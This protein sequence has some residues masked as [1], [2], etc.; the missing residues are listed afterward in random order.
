MRVKEARFE[1][2]HQVL[3]E[4]NQDKMDACIIVPDSQVEKRPNSCYYR[5]TS[6]CDP[7]S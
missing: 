2:I 1:L 3:N 6:P 5:P 7:P 4:A